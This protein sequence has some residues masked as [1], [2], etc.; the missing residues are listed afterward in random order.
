MRN[1]SKFVLIAVFVFAV[2]AIAWGKGKLL[3]LVETI[4]TLHMSQPTPQMPPNFSEVT[5]PFELV[6]KHVMLKVTV[7]NSRPLWFVLDTGDKF[8]I[9]DL[10]RAKELGLKLGGDIQVGGVGSQTTTGAFVKETTFS[11]SGFAGF[12]QPVTLAIPLKNL[13]AR[14]GHDFDGIL[15]AEFIK[16]FVVEVD[17]QLGVIKLHDKIR[18][19]YSGPGESI[20]IHLNPMGHPVFEAQVVPLGGDPIKGDFVLDIGSRG[21]LALN[22]PFVASHQ[23]LG[24]NLKT[25]KA[26]GVGGTGGESNAQYG[27]VAE[28][29]IGR[30]LFKNPITLFSEDKAGAF[31]NSAIQG[32]VGEEVVSKFKLFLDYSHDRISLEPNVSFGGPIDHAFSGLLIEAEGKDYKTYRIKDVQEHSA[33]SDVGLQKND[34]I[35]AVDGRPASELTFGEVSDILERPVTHVL[36]MGRGDQTLRVELTPRALV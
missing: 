24:P 10:D 25:I 5:I 13:A 4:S 12:S 2:A 34:V 18:F 26:I 14:F 21:S 19:A 30:Y 17:Y 22:S 9:V 8:A 27:R 28:L 35:N 33:G 3:S 32:S 36:I 7:N 31:A 15:G 6:A 23:L 1:R 11:I 20:P 16:Q 29:K